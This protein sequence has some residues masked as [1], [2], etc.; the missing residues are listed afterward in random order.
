MSIEQLEEP[1][2]SIGKTLVSF[3]ETMKGLENDPQKGGLQA[4]AIIMAINDIETIIE[5]IQ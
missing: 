2:K 1:K 3:Y 5:K 4:T